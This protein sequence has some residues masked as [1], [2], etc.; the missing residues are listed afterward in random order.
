[1]ALEPFTSEAQVRAAL[2]VTDVE[3]T[4]AT[5]ALP[6]FVKGLRLALDEVGATP[7]NGA[8]VTAFNVVAAIAE[9]DRTPVQRNL[10]DAV[11]LYAPLSVAVQCASSLPLFSQKSVTDGKAAISRHSESP[12]KEIINQCKQDA[13]RFRQNLEKRWATYNSTTSTAPK[14]PTLFTI[15]SPS[16]NPITGV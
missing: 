11:E 4:D 2:G 8:L 5:L 10:Y 12:F 3:L 15:S 16:S 6:L 1:M 13:E 9:V 14:A 7:N